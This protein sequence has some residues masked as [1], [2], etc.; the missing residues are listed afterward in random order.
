M[1]NLSR[2]LY[3]L[4]W[5]WGTAINTLVTITLASGGSKFSGRSKVGGVIYRRRM[6]KH[7]AGR[8]ATGVL[9]NA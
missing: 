1:P 4:T 6:R 5:K 7:L 3:G 8:N 2:P 9:A